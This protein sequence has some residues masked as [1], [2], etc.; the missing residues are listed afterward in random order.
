MAIQIRAAGPS[1]QEACL[2][3]LQDL[4]EVT[5]EWLS[6]W[7]GDAFDG[8]LDG[9]RGQIILAE[10]DGALLG[11]ASMSFN[12]AMRFGGEYCL[13]EELVVEPSAR[14]RGVGTQLVEAAMAAARE[15]GCVEAGAWPQSP[16]V[17]AGSSWI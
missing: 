4:S 6:K 17:V 2:E 5:G 3:L 15:R 10:D 13:L 11:L 9:V 16:S 1:D 14:G 7:A 8:L 12:L